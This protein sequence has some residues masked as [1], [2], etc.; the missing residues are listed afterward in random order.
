MATIIGIE[1]K[2]GPLLRCRVA[3][4]EREGERGREPA[5][6]NAKQS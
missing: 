3:S 4:G 5:K 1:R 6:D 2:D